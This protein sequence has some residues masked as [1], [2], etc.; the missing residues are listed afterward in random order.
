M[1]LLRCHHLD[2]VHA[3]RFE[4]F[5][6]MSWLYWEDS[7]SKAKENWENSATLKVRLGF[8]TDLKSE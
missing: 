3:R 8:K 6:L 7:W 1:K 4:D 5:D 2:Q